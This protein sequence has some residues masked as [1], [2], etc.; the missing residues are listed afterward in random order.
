MSA[1]FH[2]FAKMQSPDQ[3]ARLAER[4]GATLG[5]GDCLLLG[6]PV[7][8]GKTHFARHLIW[9]LMQVPEDVPSPTFTLIQTYDTKAG[10][11]WHADLYRLTSLDEIEELGLTEAF[12]QAVCL[13]EWPHMLGPLVPADALQLSFL[14]DPDDENARMITLDTTS[15]RWAPLLKQLANDRSA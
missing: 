12:G 13:V 2:Y 10:E 8:A 15:V 5:A 9:S 3:T 7:G 4:V 6:G 14:P 11:L 1:P